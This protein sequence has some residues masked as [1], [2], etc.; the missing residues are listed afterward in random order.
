[1]SK[2]ISYKKNLIERLKKPK[3]AVAYLNAALADDIRVFLIALRDVTEALGL[4]LN[5]KTAAI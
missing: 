1:M 3:E 5:I 2:S 4:K